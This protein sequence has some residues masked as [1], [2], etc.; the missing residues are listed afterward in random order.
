M[1]IMLLAGLFLAI[2]ISAAGSPLNGSEGRFPQLVRTF[3]TTK[4]G[5]PSDNVQA[6]TIGRDGEVY[7]VAGG[8]VACEAGGRWQ[9]M[10]GPAEV[11]A[12]FAPGSG[13]VCLAAA[14]DGVWA[15][16]DGSWTKEPGSPAKASSFAAEPDGTV[17]ALAPSG[18]W[19]RP[20]GWELVD[21]LDDEMAGPREI[22]PT[23]P[24][25]CYV[26]DPAGLF[27]LT[28][29]RKYWL[30]L[31]VRPEGLPSSDVRSVCRLDK[32]HLLVAT[33]KGLT[34]TNG[35]RGWRTLTG[36]DG[37]PIPDLTSVCAATD[38]TVWLGSAQG[39][40]RWR[41][42]EWTYFASKRWLPDDK[43]QAIAPSADGSVWVGTPKGLSHIFTRMMSL[44]EK[45]AIFQK[46]LESR[47]RRFGY[48]TVLQLKSEGL[49]EGA[50]Q[51]ISDNDGLWTALYIASQS[52]RYA[53]TKDNAA[54]AQAWRSMQALLRLESI[55]GI[56][57]FPARAICNENEPAFRRR[58]LDKDDEWH[59]SPVEKR[60]W[61]KGET[62]SDEI[63]GHY[64]GWF[65]FYQLA[66]DEE[67]K[68]LVRAT[69]KRVTDH[70]LDHNYRLVDLDGRPT[71]WGYWGP[72]TLNDDPQWWEER[73]L[74]ST[75][76]LSH[77]KVAMHIVGDPRYE[78]A[79]QALVKEHHYALNAL[80]ARIPGAVN[81]DSQLTYLAFY[82]LLQLE[83][84][85][86]LRALY[87]AG[88]R[89]QW[90]DNRIEQNPLWNLFYGAGTGEPCDVEAAVNS[91]QEIPL[92]LIEW[93][94][95]NSHRAD[96]RYREAADRKGVRQPLTPLN[97]IERP[98]DKWD[99][100]PYVLDD[101]AGLGETDQTMW[102]L[103]Y[104]LGRYHRLI[105]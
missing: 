102:L 38:G 88:Q 20:K 21:R 85:P 89:R 43:V 73:G 103:P 71:T 61:W 87:Q 63:A 82:P 26:A 32:E 35:R 41:K 58:G 86:G 45:A 97:F 1:Y 59:P 29:K 13:T 3:V 24:N 62:S 25:G 40:M 17:W 27:G 83:K 15:L 48:V 19:R 101:G 9:R 95:K 98:M 76:M 52:C 57:G 14:Q 55:T 5:L 50:E 56:S 33:D 90:L 78:K 79:Y 22:C 6:V 72:D 28:G 75:E 70:L 60:W 51:E 65:L 8:A 92:D 49:L 100:N 93:R 64:F 77:L 46:D 12:L 42:G 18:F 104:W 69:V 96:I 37:L 44:A 4:E 39:L 99:H 34:L 7:A 105:E 84:D 31:E 66:A 2:S 81:H 30:K 10:A 80:G 16:R 47:P 36:A 54:R 74:G 68:R 23:G 91:L 67:Q 53:V 11:K 94:I